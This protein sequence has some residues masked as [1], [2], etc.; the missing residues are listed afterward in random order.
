MTSTTLLPFQPDAMTPAQ[1]AAFTPST[2]AAFDGE[3]AGYDTGKGTVKLPYGE[4]APAD[5]LRRMIEFRVR[6]FERDGVKWM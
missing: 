1:L 3:L 4:P 2:R 5:L 6:A